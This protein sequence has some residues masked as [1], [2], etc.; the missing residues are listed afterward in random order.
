MQQE[1]YGAAAEK[2]AENILEDLFTLVLDWPLSDINNQ[3]GYADLLLTSLGIKYLIVEVKRP[4]ALAWNRRAVEAALDQAH[5]YADEQKVRCIGVS[6]G[7]MLYAADIEHGGL[8]DRVFV[9]L[10]SSEPQESLWWL[11]V[12]GIY[13]P[14]E[15]TKDATLRLLP[16]IPQEET[17]E[18][19]LPYSALLHPRYGL[20]ARCFGYVGDASDPRT[21]KLPYLLADGT[22]DI[23]R[24][25]K[26]IGSILSNYRGLR[27]SSIPE[28]DIPD[29][30][31]RLACAA[32][33]VGKL[34]GQSGRISKTYRQLAEALEQLDRLDEVMSGDG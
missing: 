9:S 22:A 28:K 24:L 29:V 15:D 8:Q 5:R 23:T 1:R 33:R 16:E 10:E 3:V 4:G 21:W 34:P 32:A 12:Y 25:P 13:Q 31:V 20:P 14:R 18:T 6:D 27:V 19:G 2:V 26:A 7:V 11:S 17:I 30:L